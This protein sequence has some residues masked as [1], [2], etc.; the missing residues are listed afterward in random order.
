MSAVFSECNRYRYR[1]DR[2]LDTPLLGPGGRVV[3]VGLN[4]S[5]AGRVIANKEIGDPTATRMENF[6]GSWGYDAFTIVNPFARVSTDPKALVGM[7]RDEAV[8]PENDRYIAEAI[9]DAALVVPAWG[10]SCPPALA[11]RLTDVLAT[12]RA[13]GPVYHLGLTQKGNPRHP[14]RLLG[15]T[16][17]T[18]WKE[19]A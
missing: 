18:L 10:D 3:F 2:Q 1:L 8:G 14:L 19:A 6:T 5:I 17:P 4:P 9:Q 13:A 11:G 12:L 7:D 15:N 16:E